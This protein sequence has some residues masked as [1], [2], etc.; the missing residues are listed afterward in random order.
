[1]STKSADNMEKII[2]PSVNHEMMRF[3]LAQR[4]VIESTYEDEKNP[5]AITENY[6][7]WLAP[8]KDKKKAAR[9]FVTITPDVKYMIAHVF[10]SMIE[11]TQRIEPINLKSLSLVSVTDDERRLIEAQT[12]RE[13]DRI[14]R[15][16]QLLENKQ[17]KYL[18]DS[19]EDANV[20]CVYRFVADY[21]NHWKIPISSTL[22]LAHDD[23]NYFQQKSSQLIKDH[24]LVANVVANTFNAFMRVLS[25]NA[26]DMLFENHGTFN[27]DFLCGILR[28]NGCSYEMLDELKKSVPAPAPRKKKETT[29]DAATSST[30]ST[31]STAATTEATTSTTSTAAAAP[32]PTN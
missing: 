31:S 11:E 24:A 1:M 26:C 21:I 4:K 8:T 16:K 32:A 6:E 7:Q 17:I 18:A 27:Q 23:K 30:T 20:Y 13:A 29:A 19:A 22:A 9:A 15:I 14:E 5:H 10:I 25:K 28:M 2:V 12:P 3:I